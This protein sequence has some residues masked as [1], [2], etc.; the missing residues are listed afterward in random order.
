MV[1]GSGVV[2]ERRILN[3]A[4]ESAYIE[5]TALAAGIRTHGQTGRGSITDLYEGFHYNLGI[6]IDLTCDLEEMNSDKD[7]VEKSLSWLDKA[8][9]ANDVEA[10]SIEGRE[11]FKEYKRALNRCGLIALPARGK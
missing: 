11:M 6:L 2:Q 3:E 7:L 5:C 10:R 1:Q 8:F 9:R 4:I